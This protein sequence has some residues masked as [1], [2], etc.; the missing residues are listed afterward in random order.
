MDS[1][2]LIFHVKTDDI[3]KDVAENVET[4][5]STSNFELDRPL[6]K[7]KNDKVIGLTKYQ[8]GGEIMK[9]FVGLR[10]KP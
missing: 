10:A 3:C 1:Y 4:R 6:L 2:S 8:L 9:E 7:G 5:F